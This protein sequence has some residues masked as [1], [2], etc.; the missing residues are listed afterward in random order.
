MGSK[1]MRAG[2][3]WE[4]LVTFCELGAETVMDLRMGVERLTA[5]LLNAAGLMSTILKGLCDGFVNG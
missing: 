1:S 4:V 5:L 3:I 2:M